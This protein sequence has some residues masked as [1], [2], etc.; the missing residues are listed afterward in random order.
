M[1]RTAEMATHIPLLVRVF[2]ASEGDVLELGTGYF[3]TLILR[4]LCEMFD[5]ELWSYENRRRWYD[6]VKKDKPYHHVF[7][8]ERW[9]DADIERRWGMA[10]VDHA[11]NSRRVVEIERLANCAEY[12]VIHDT[13]PNAESA[14]LPTDYGYEKIWHLFK[15][16]YDYTDL[17]PWTSVVSNFHGIDCY[18]TR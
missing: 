16:R 17:V 1:R 18:A 4:W 8:V 12:I 5:R 7:Y 13:Q 6:R 2:T 9:E 10:F 11:P 3:S 14:G 15:H